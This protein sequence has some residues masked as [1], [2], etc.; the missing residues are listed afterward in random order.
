MLVATP[1]DDVDEVVKSA[2]DTRYG[3]AANIWTRELSRAHLTARRLQAGMVWINAHGM[4][5]TSAPFCGMK[6]SGWGREVGED[7]VLHYM[8]TKTVMALLGD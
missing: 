4:K 3:L 7:G 6:E 5:D 2:N 8:E 1:F